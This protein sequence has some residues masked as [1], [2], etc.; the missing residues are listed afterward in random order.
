LPDRHWPAYCRH[1]IETLNTLATADCHA[2]IS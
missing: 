1:S 2:G